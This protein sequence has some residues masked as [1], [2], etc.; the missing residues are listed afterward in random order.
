MQAT[1]V[2]MFQPAEEKSTGAMLMVEENVL[3]KVEAIFGIHLMPHK[4]ILHSTWD[5]FLVMK[6]FKSLHP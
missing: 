2:L 5:I 3:D 6:Q 4:S 1:V